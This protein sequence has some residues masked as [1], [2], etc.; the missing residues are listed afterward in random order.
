MKANMLVTNVN[1]ADP[2]RLTAFYKD[3]V[4]LSHDPNSGGFVISESAMFVIDAHSDITGATKEPA[5]VLLSFF[6]DDIAAEEERLKA[7]GVEFSRSQG[8]EEW[9]GT[10]STFKDPD[11]NYV[12]L[13]QAPG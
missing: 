8:K 12:Q 1:S 5:R 11:G 6:V 10:F 13:G 9:G 4:G 2:E 3:V 7:A